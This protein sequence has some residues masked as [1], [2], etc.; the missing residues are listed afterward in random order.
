MKK[1]IL[2][3]DP[4]IDELRN[5]IR[6]TFDQLPKTNE[7]KRLKVHSIIEKTPRAD[8]LTVHTAIID[9]CNYYRKP[10][11]EGS[12]NNQYTKIA[13]FL[14]EAKRFRTIHMSEYTLVFI[15]AHQKILAHAGSQI[16]AYFKKSIPQE[17]QMNTFFNPGMCIVL[18]QKPFAVSLKER[19]IL[20]NELPTRASDETREQDTNN[21]LAS[22]IPPKPKGW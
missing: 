1:I 3:N 11:K 9:A 17:N 18:D 15:V 20:H 8:F 21:T 7:M 16:S 12:L 4:T 14:D 2:I 22:D 19:W 13:D 10:H 5:I 6:Y